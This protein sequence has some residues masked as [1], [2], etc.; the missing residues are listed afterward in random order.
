MIALFMDTGLVSLALPFLDMQQAVLAVL[1]MGVLT[2]FVL[3]VQLYQ[4]IISLDRRMTELVQ[5]LAIHDYVKET[6]AT[7]K[8]D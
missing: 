7:G 1:V 5:N 2:T 8:E 3:I 4:Q 6:S